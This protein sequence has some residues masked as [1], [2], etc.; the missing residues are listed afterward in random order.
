MNNTITVLIPTKNREKLLKNCLESLFSQS[1]KPNQIIIVNDGS[2]DGTKSFLDSLSAKYDFVNVINREKSG[3]VNVARNEGIKINKSK[4][5]AFLDDDDFFVENA[6]STMIDRLKNLSQYGVV[7]FNTLIKTDK[8]DFNGGFQFKE[9]LNFYDPNYYEVVTKFNLKGDCK[10]VFNSEIFKTEKYWFPESVNGF[11]SIVIRKIIR[12]G[13][14]V[15]YIS[16]IL[17][18]INQRS[19][20]DHISISA[21]AKNPK[22]YFE[23]HVKDFLDNEDFYISNKNVLYKKY[24]EMVKLAVRS[25][26]YL[27]LFKFSIKLILSF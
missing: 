25:G 14:G 24:I 13:L 4:W 27:D 19:D 23:V 21:P 10:P 26:D 5:I 16:D 3:G 20:V 11:E 22:A 8:I 1:I 17:T 18:V 12:D 6:I 2:S 9:D 15:R 7:F